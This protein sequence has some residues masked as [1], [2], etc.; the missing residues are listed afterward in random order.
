MSTERQKMI[1]IMA[2]YILVGCMSGLLLGVFVGALGATDI[3][4]MI[5][6]TR[7]QP[8]I[9]APVRDITI[10]IDTSQQQKLFDQLRK[11]ADKWRYAVRIAPSNSSAKSFAVQ[12]WRYDMKLSGLYETELGILKIGFYNTRSTSQNPWWF[13]DDEIKDLKSLINEVPNATITVK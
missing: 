13:F 8:K 1:W 10:T 4:A 5:E 7:N 12:M 3:K 2:G 6:K 9:E 11:F